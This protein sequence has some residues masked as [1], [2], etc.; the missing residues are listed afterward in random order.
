MIVDMYLPDDGILSRTCSN[1]DILLRLNKLIMHNVN[2][3]QMYCVETVTS[4]RIII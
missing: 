4:I 3:S 1:I 2:E